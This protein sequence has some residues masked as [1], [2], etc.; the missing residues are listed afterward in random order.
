MSVQQSKKFYRII[1][2]DKKTGR[3]ISDEEQRNNVFLGSWNHGFLIPQHLQAPQSFIMTVEFL[4][5]EHY[6]KPYA[7]R[8]AAQQKGQNKAKVISAARQKEIDAANEKALVLRRAR[9]MNQIELAFEK[10][11]KDAIKFVTC[12]SCNDVV[13]WIGLS[14]DNPGSTV[15]DPE[16]IT[17]AWCAE[18][19]HMHTNRQYWPYKTTAVVDCSWLE[20][21]YDGL[22]QIYI[23]RPQPGDSHA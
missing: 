9:I 7:A 23:N 10:K 11:R 16:Q 20:F 2:K 18:H 12:D 3:V 5:E 6:K 13:K 22:R 21:F 14:H 4:R 8:L 15:I 17:G 1:V 19:F